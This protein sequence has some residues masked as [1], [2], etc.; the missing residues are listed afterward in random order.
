MRDRD[1]NLTS[2]E[3]G[4][5]ADEVGLV[6]ESVFLSADSKAGYAVERS[7]FTVAWA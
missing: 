7:T 3:V 4:L 2:V 1:L 6:A 5:V